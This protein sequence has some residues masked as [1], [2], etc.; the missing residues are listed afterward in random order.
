MS[1]GLPVQA[2]LSEKVLT[3]FLPTHPPLP[4]RAGQLR[5]R[6]I[7]PGWACLG[8]G[9]QSRATLLER[10]TSQKGDEE[11]PPVEGC[12]TET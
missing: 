7:G 11:R 6:R 1:P 2:W 3:L 10:G 5:G 9:Q 8:H 4:G 12:H